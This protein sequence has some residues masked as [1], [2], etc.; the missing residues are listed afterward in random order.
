[1][2]DATDERII[3]AWLNKHGVTA[4]QFGADDLSEFIG[5]IEGE[6][7]EWCVI[8]SASRGI[9]GPHFRRL[10]RALVITDTDLWTADDDECVSTS[11]IPLFHR[12]DEIAASSK[13]FWDDY[14]SFGLVEP[15]PKD[16]SADIL[17]LRKPKFGGP[18]RTALR[19]QRSTDV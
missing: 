14:E 10:F 17:P 3:Q 5:T 12:C 16:T 9:F 4:I 15:K 1:V 18:I 6:V 7:V 2:F 11:L 19:N 8:A 13:Q